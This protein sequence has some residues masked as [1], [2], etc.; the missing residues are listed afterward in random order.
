VVKL[1]F[2]LKETTFGRIQF[3]F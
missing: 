3:H 1:R 2:K